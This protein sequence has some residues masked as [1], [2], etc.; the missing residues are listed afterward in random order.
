VLVDHALATWR[1]NRVE[2]VVATENRRSRAIPE[3]LGFHEEGTLRQFQLV[4]GR[5]LDCVSYS[6]LAT[7]EQ[8]ARA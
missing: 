6:M 8:G 1:L 3:R 2:I 7:D 4:D 5:Y